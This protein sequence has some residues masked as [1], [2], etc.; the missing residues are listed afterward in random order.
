[1][2]KQRILLLSFLLCLTFTI[3][4][5][6]QISSGG[7]PRSFSRIAKANIP[8]ITTPNVDV[9]K[10]LAEDEA[11]SK[12]G[13]P[14][15]FGAPF[16]VNYTLDNSGV[17]ETLPD[18]GRL[19]TLRIE[20]QGAYSI[21]LL[22]DFFE[23]PEGAELF[24]YNESRTDVI[25]AFTSKNNHPYQKF[26]TAPIKGSVSILE[27]YEPADAD[28][29]GF[30]SIS[31]IVHGYKNI[32]DQNVLKGIADYG[33]S[34]SCNNNVNCP[35]GDPWQ[36]QKRGVAM[37]LLG[38]GTRWCSGS[39]IN[40]VRE[41]FTPYFLSADHCL[42]G[43]QYWI[44]MFN[45]ESPECIN[46]NGPTNMTV[47]G[48]TL[49][50]SNS[51]S[52][53][54]LVEL[55]ATPPDDYEVYYSG[56]SNIDTPSPQ[57][58]GIHHPSGDIKKISFDYEPVTSTNYLA[59][60]GVTHWRIGSWND[61]TTEG[62]SSGSPLF[63]DNHRI[64][65]QLHGGY[66][67]CT[68]ITPDWYGKF[69][70]SWDYGSSST[71]RLR[72]WLDPDNSGAT[73]LDGLDAAR[74]AFDND[75]SI[76]WSPFT[77]NFTDNS[78]ENVVSWIWDFG[79]GDTSYVQHPTHIY[80]IPGLYDVKLEIEND[81]G[82]FYTKLKVDLIASLADTVIGYEVELISETQ[83]VMEINAKNNVP[84]NYFKIP[85]E[86]LGDI[87][88]VLD[89]FSTVGLRTEYFEDDLN[90]VHNNPN[91]KQNTLKIRAS[92]NGSVAELPPGEGPIAK[93]YFSVGPG[94]NPGD[95]TIISLGGYISG[96]TEF[97]PYY[98][99]SML[100]F[101]PPTVDGLVTVGTCCLLRGDVNHNGSI[102]ISDITY[103]VDYFFQQG[104]APE[105]GDEADVNSDGNIIISD[106][107][108]LVDYI[109]NGGPAPGP[110]V[111]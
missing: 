21:N 37:V 29:P 47:S 61:G 54:A 107:T 101:Q 68:S 8:T 9:A 109:F 103:M 56:W 14:F 95:S 52:D 72:D 62:G 17:W 70:K 39:M 60:T 5:W 33:A 71:N 111:P 27:Y 105:C 74:V 24:I 49:R 28:F 57:S 46:I 75:L 13:I 34:G 45:Y 80:D 94:I 42:G 38:S 48:T 4:S 78:N 58:V 83:F 11:E 15:R 93:L 53:F 20:C 59:S 89:S 19:W 85:V 108:M 106:L 40:N 35:E 32:F 110:C 22:Y 98:Y 91:G 44:I 31:R 10:M 6:G 51:Y 36:E 65:G 18:G 81:I 25:G 90:Y 2:K 102:G 66:A 64:V 99:G 3:P 12:L 43:E 55:S 97:L 84:V 73:T 30:I 1:M 88:L 69:A 41:D 67:S 96:V 23:I 63:D 104:P 50:A 82:E 77:V 76:G 79:D 26:S 92:T 7:T 100:D 86:Y 16:D 87:D